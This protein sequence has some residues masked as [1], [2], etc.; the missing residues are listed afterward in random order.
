MALLNFKSKK[1]FDVAI[2]GTSGLPPTYGGF[3][4]LASQLVKHLSVSGTNFLIVADKTKSNIEQ[5]GLK[6]LARKWCTLRY[7]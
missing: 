4:T 6:Q 5:S 3:E 7:L 1:P 2:L